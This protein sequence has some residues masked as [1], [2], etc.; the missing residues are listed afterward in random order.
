MAIFHIS[1][2]V[3]ATF[4]ARRF[5]CIY[6]RVKE[7]ALTLRIEFALLQTQGLAVPQ[8]FSPAEGCV[9]VWH[10]C[11]GGSDVL[12]FG[13]GFKRNIVQILKKLLQ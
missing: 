8:F 4:F 6:I 3:R 11:Q 10:V 1:S 13:A 12:L 2:F 7:L 9:F 5:K